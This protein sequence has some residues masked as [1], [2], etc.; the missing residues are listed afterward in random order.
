MDK[1][2]AI[3]LAAG[4][5]T[6]MGKDNKLLLP[7]GGGTVIRR[8]V[9]TY[10]AAIDGVVTVVTGFE[11]D[12]I[13]E[14]LAGLDL[15]FVHNR[16]FADGQQGSVAV[17]LGAAPP[18]EVL[19]IGLGDQPLL[20]PADLQA[21]FAAQA[22]APEKIAI[23]FRGEDRGNPLAVP[24][25][26]RARLTENA[27]RPG[28]LRFTRDNPQLVTRVEMTTDGPFTDVDTPEAYGAL[29]PKAGAKE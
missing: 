23:P 24:A 5:S 11:A 17:G 16:D 12:D 26:L 8:V 27:E 18:A 6:R 29:A 22:N 21:I 20:T 13:T 7:W 19:F 10:L 15:A 4:L 2:G 14:A 28:C 9:E 1:E 3:I 25:A